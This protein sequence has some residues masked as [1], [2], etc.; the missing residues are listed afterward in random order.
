MD[1]KHINYHKDESNPDSILFDKSSSGLNSIVWGKAGWTFL[2]SVTF[3]FPVDPTTEDKNNYLI[4]YEKLGNVMPCRLCRES[5]L[6]FITEPDTLLSIETFKNRESVV[7]WLYKIHNKVNKKL[8]VDYKVEFEEFVERFESFRARCVPEAN[9]CVVPL[10]ARSQAF[11]NACIRD[12]PVITSDIAE[13]FIPYAKRRNLG[14]QYFE[15][16]HTIKGIVDNRHAHEE[17][18]RKRNELCDKLIDKIR[19]D[20]IGSLE[21][22]GEFEGMPT[23]P[24]L[25]LI[26]MLSTTM[27]INNLKEV[28]NKKKQN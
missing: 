24:E 11:N 26:F 4:F 22:F 10:H 19:K 15:F 9:G 20:S 12:C 23:M 5:Y 3:G 28:I 6:K 17:L 21:T 18:W 25:K 16:F 13:S 14:K 1:I 7:R 2:H 8:G 27:N